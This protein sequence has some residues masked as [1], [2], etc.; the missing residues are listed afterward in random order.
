MRD[1]YSPGH[2]RQQ[3]TPEAEADRRAFRCIGRQSGCSPLPSISP[4]SA[5]QRFALPC[6]CVLDSRHNCFARSHQSSL[7]TPKT[8]R[9]PD[10]LPSRPVQIYYASQPY[11]TIYAHIRARPRQSS[12]PSAGS[13]LARGPHQPVCCHH[14]HPHRH[15]P[16]L[17]AGPRAACLSRTAPEQARSTRSRNFLGSTMTLER[18]PGPFVF[19]PRSSGRRSSSTKAEAPR[20]N[21]AVAAASAQRPG[22]V[23]RNSEYPTSPTQAA[24]PKPRHIAHKSSSAIPTL[25]TLAIPREPNLSATKTTMSAS[26]A[27]S[28]STAADLLRQAMMQR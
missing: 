21:V 20:V 23:T 7:P 25:S 28:G 13:R 12:P 19:P 5:H 10:S 6:L 9:C 15:P 22:L 4:C 27:A 11:T 26:G 3:M 8:R 17:A 1:S 16:Q 2:G 18:L 24:R 14:P